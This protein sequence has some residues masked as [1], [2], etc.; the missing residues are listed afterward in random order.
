MRRAGKKDDPLKREGGVGIT[1]AKIGLL[2]DNF[3]DVPGSSEPLL[4]YAKNI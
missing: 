3:S 4:R 1:A 2:I